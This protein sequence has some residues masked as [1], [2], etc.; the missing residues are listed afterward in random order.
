[1][2]RL[3]MGVDV[4][5][6]GGETL[7]S[8]ASISVPSSYV[9]EFGLWFFNRLDNHPECVQNRSNG[10][11]Y[12]CIGWWLWES[13]TYHH[14]RLFVRVQCYL[15]DTL[16]EELCLKGKCMRTTH[17]SQVPH[18]IYVVISEAHTYALVCSCSL[19]KWKDSNEKKTNNFLVKRALH[20]TR[21]Y[22]L[23]RPLD[24]CMWGMKKCKV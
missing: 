6:S 1:M 10:Y 12:W 7:R 23:D 19:W 24:A 3:I 11:N 17:P 2:P 5:T 15:D 9:M 16:R 18:I 22:G 14:L 20:V 8:D 4:N 13:V 21:R